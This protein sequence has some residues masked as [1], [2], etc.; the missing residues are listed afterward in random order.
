MTNVFYLL[1]STF[2]SLYLLSIFKSLLLRYYLGWIGQRT[3]ALA[4]YAIGIS[5][6]YEGIGL[7]LLDGLLSGFVS[8]APALSGHP[9]Y[10]RGGVGSQ[11][12]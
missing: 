9:L 1:I 6:Y 4:I 2:I 11:Q 5:D 8:Y 12:S 10:L 3:E 7:K